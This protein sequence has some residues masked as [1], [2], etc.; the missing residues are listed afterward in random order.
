MY[1][2]HAGEGDRDVLVVRAA[3]VFVFEPLQLRPRFVVPTALDQDVG[4]QLPTLGR[5]VA[6]AF[7]GS[8][9]PVLRRREIATLPETSKR[10][11]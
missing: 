10:P 3:S 11:C 9:E 8:L 7:D 5:A 1:A 4:E 2:Q 6:R